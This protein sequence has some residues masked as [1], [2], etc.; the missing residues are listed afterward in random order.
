MKVTMTVPKG[1]TARSLQVPGPIFETEAPDA[2]LAQA[3][4][5]AAANRR[6]SPAHTKDRSQ[7]RGGGRKPWRQKGTGNAR[8][9]SRRSP[10][11]RGGGVTFGP[12]P[13]IN[14][15]LAMPTRMRRAALL[16]ATSAL[17][18]AGQVSVIPD[19][20]IASPS[21]KS[22]LSILTAL[23]LSPS[24]S[25]IVL[26]EPDEAVLRSSDNLRD[27]TVV[28][29]SY[30]SVTQILGSGRLVFT[31]SGLKRFCGLC[32]GAEPAKAKR[33]QAAKTAVRKEPTGDAS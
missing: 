1:K 22:F 6:L 31:E 4:R 19:F 24:R 8:A 5:T 14:H 20:D 16:A 23:E 2:L 26:A 21:T 9:G 11:W 28:S 15:A 32:A 18:R 7:V 13:E 3:V 30:L 27:C 12:T 17:W 25:T 10:L 33:D 29:A